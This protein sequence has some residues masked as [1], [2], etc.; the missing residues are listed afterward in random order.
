MTRFI[1]DDFLL[2]LDYELYCLF[3]DNSN[4]VHKFYEDFV[5]T[6][7]NIVD[8]FASLRTATKK[9][10]LGLKPWISSDLMKSI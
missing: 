9:E 5:E 10:K 3:K 6:F 4:N 1:F 2:A 7:T 8:Q